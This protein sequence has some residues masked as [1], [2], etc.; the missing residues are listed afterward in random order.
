MG[1]RERG[2]AMYRF[3]HAVPNIAIS[4]VEY[5]FDNIGLTASVNVLL[6][7]RASVNELSCANVSVS[8]LS[9]AHAAR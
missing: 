4:T 2:E 6:C 7:E 9:C 8:E 5:K 3:F 1:D